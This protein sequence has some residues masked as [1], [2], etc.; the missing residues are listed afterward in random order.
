MRKKLHFFSLCLF[1]VTIVGCK[2]TR[3]IESGQH[4]LTKNVIHFNGDNRFDY[5][6]D[7]EDI[8]SAIKQRTNRTVFGFIPFH[9][10]VWNYAKSRK[11]EG[12]LNQ[13]LLNVVGEEPVLYEPILH[14]KSK[15]QIVKILKNQGYFK[16]L[17]QYTGP[18][19][20]SMVHPLQP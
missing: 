9:I 15:D 17:Y 10:S 8:E 5:D 19:N 7:F 11:K 12:K 6:A 2:T 20:L 3:H 1:L 18:V 13:Y 14:E 16:N 4:L